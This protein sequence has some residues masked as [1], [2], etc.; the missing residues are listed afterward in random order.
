MTGDGRAAAAMLGCGEPSRAIATWKIAESMATTSIFWAAE[1]WLVVGFGV[2]LVVLVLAGVLI[3]SATRRNPQDVDPT[4]TTVSLPPDLEGNRRSLRVPGGKYVA[5]MERMV[6]SRRSELELLLKPATAD[7]IRRRWHDELTE[8]ERVAMLRK[9]AREV[10]LAIAAHLCGDVALLPDVCPELDEPSLTRFAAA[11]AGLFTFA[12]TLANNNWPSPTTKRTHA[13]RA[14]VA[15][16][17][18]RSSGGA[19]RSARARFF[20][21]FRRL[22]LLAFCT[23]VATELDAAS[24]RSV[25]E[26]RA[27]R[28]DL[29]RKAARALGIWAAS[30]MGLR[31][32]THAL[33]RL[34]GAGIGAI[35]GSGARAEL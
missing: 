23:A 17:I 20:E 18:E 31:L 21:R 11:P 27:A 22:C 28:R 34:G 2:L 29:A 12:R 3:Y 10:G 33:G 6:E 15:E 30:V 8:A 5:A 1:L 9:Q 32:F 13:I 19:E 24:E 16:H 26:R 14:A 7:P 35:G 4:A 25:A